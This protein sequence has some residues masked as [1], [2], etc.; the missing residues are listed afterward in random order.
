MG[1]MEIKHNHQNTCRCKI[2]LVA[3]E[4][5][6]D[7]LGAELIKSLNN[8]FRGAFEFSGCGGPLMGDTGFH[9]LFNIDPLSVM[10]FTDVVKVYPLAKKRV[11][12]LANYARD[13]QV[14]AVV[15][16]DGWAFSRLGAKKM[17]AVAPQAKLI[18]YSAPQIWASRP[19]RINFVKKYF[20]RVMTLLP[21]EAS[22]FEKQNITA[23]FVGNSVF[24]ATYNAYEQ[25]RNMGFDF[26][27]RHKIGSNSLLVV[28]PGSRKGEIAHLE[29]VFK[30]SV[31]LLKKR[32]EKEH[33]TKQKLHIVVPVAPSVKD[34]VREKM[35]DW[36]NVLFV[37]ADDKLAAIAAGDAA[38]A[39]SGTVTTEIAI[40]KTPMVIA[41][42]VDWLT[43]IWAKRVIIT[44][45]ANILNFMA[46]REIIPEL[47]QKDCQPETLADRLFTLLTNEDVR[48]AQIDGLSPYLQQLSLDG[49]ASS[50]LAA[51]ALY[52]WLEETN[53]KS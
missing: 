26:R 49:P 22:I 20:D 31:T 47:L 28:L 39:A 1:A 8:N 53:L 3:V 25:N 34:I 48:R 50:D 16:I 6:G 24:Q 46:N 9:S 40:A 43:A 21:F 18:K 38:L 52:D 15:F 44:R 35:R 17:R 29:P 45:F 19:Q 32:F 11:Q 13:Q 23:R 2:M 33:V 27:K 41:Y 30:E 51:Q 14:A 7:A 36:E 42:K 10:G 5:S 37:G 4:A 12:E